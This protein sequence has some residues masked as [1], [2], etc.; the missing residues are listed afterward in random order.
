PMDGEES[1]ACWVMVDEDW[2]PST[3]LVLIGD[4]P[5][6]IAMLSERT[7]P[8]NSLMGEKDK[9]DYPTPRLVSSDY[10]S[11][12]MHGDAQKTAPVRDLEALRRKNELYTGEQGRYAYSNRTMLDKRAVNAVPDTA[13]AA[14]YT[15]L[16]AGS[17]TLAPVKIANGYRWSDKTGEWVD[18]NTQGQ[19]VAYGDKN[20]NTVWMVRDKGG[21]LRGVIDA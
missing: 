11:L 20:N 18:Y 19:V 5:I 21:T 7:T 17:M 4:K 1:K 2:K 16:A 10:F 9:E 13:S 3:G 6:G 14:A 12:C 15:Q 8:F